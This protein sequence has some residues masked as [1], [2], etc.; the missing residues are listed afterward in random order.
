M[1]IPV[2]AGSVN[3][4]ECDENDHLNVRFF[5]HKMQ[6]TLQ[7]GLIQSGLALPEN[8]DPICRG[9]VHQHMRHQA[10]ARIAVPITGLFGI[11]ESTPTRVRVLTELRNTVT[12]AVLCTYLLDI[13]GEFDRPVIANLTCPE[14]AAP[15]GV[16]AEDFFLKDRSAA[17]LIAIG[18]NVIGRGVIQPEECDADGFLQ[19][20]MYMGRNSDSMPNLF[21]L[22]ESAERGNGV[23]GGA[24]LEYRLNRFGHLR[25]GSRFE[26]ISGVKNLGEKTQTFVH[27]LFDVDTGEMITGSEAVAISMDLV[28]RKSIPIPP[29]RRE[30]MERMLIQV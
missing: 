22:F 16:E 2:Y 15:R 18:C 6:Q 14:Y 1:L 4:W 9:V 13:T 5:A 21:A 10:E 27:V 25:R 23:V 19:T 7:F 11:I 8:V 30:K 12:E 24:V 26:L 20:Y 28:A 29:D 3:R 17:E